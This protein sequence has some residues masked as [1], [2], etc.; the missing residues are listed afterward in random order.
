MDR[1][2]AENYVVVGG[3]KRQFADG[4]PGTTVDAGHLNAVQEEIVGVVEAAGFAPSASTNG[5]LL[6]AITK[7][8]ND[9]LSMW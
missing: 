4:P 2:T 1:T 3:V 6:A 5:Q 9:Q 8:K 7:L